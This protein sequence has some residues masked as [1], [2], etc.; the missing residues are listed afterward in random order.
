M[1][2]RRW[3]YAVAVLLGCA[4]ALL[5]H[6]P[7]AWVASAVAG[8]SG[9]HVLLSNAQGSWRDGR[10]LVVLSAG[11]QGRDASALPGQLSW[12]IGLRRL[13][14]GVIELRLNWPPLAAGPLRARLEP[15]FGGWDLVQQGGP[16]MAAFPAVLLEGLGTPWNT[17]APRGMVHVRLQDLSLRMAAGRLDLGGSL[18]AQAMDMSSRLSTLAPL[19]SYRVDVEG[20]GASA[21]VRLS[22]LSGALILA[23]DGVWNG[24]RMQFSGTARA[25]PGRE[26]SLATLLGLLGPR[27]GDH[28]RIGL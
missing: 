27:Q 3:P 26:Q 1:T 24:Q 6:A 4:W 9:G 21:S 13:W 15:R 23:G 2:S 19:G 22:T 20:R 17:L 8:A 28:V 16:W 5:A 14:A 25:A 7:A 10:A 11:P 18:R 12:N